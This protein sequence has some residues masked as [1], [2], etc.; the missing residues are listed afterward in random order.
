MNFRLGKYYL[1]GFFFKFMDWVVG[2]RYGLN[3]LV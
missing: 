1:V 2:E 3:K